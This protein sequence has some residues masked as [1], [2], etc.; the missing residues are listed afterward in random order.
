MSRTYRINK[1]ADIRMSGRPSDIVT[2]AP[3]AQVYA[4]KPP[5]FTGLLPKLNVREGDAVKAGTSIFYDKKMPLVQYASPVSGVVKEI[6]RGAKRRI[7]AVVI[8]AD[9]KNSNVDFGVLEVEKSD[10]ETLISRILEGGMFPFFKQRPFDVV[11]NPE[12]KPRS[13]HV[14]GFDSSPLAANTSIALENRLSSFQT[15]IKVLAAISGEGGVHLGIKA[16]ETY[17]KGV[18]HCSVSEFDGPHPSGNVGVQ[19]NHIAP[20]NK[21]EVVWTIGLQDVANLGSLFL[22]GNYTP[23]RVVAC[24]GSECKKPQHVKTIIGASVK[25]IV[26]IPS[27]SQNGED[28]R[29]ISGSPLTGDKI[30]Q[31]GFLGAYH[32]AIALLP[33]GNQPKFLLTEGWLGLGLKRFSLSHSFLTWLMPKSKEWILD[34]N[35][36]GEERA[37][38]VTGQYEKVFPMDIYPVHLVKSIIVND[39][40][41]MEKLGIYEV[42]PEDFALCEYGCTSKIGVQQIVREGLDNLRNELG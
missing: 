32:S 12:D 6:V 17:L 20:I 25:S 18:T 24:G 4:V 16:G 5:D 38:V 29:I 33:E 13:I 41:S 26:E 2:E 22:T 35:M 28:V 21:G 23:S 9:N 19:I 11:A 42:A 31:D 36:G 30:T 27:N 15:G 3:A 1:G 8:E 37:F 40:D 39:I 7:L 14:S 10:R 34:T